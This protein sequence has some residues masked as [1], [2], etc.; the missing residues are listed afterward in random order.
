[1][2]RLETESSF[3][4]LISEAKQF[5]NKGNSNKE[6][7]FVKTQIKENNIVKMGKLPDL[8]LP[9]FLGSYEKWFSFKYMFD[10]LVDSRT[11]LSDTDK[12]LYLKLCCKNDALKLIESL[13]VTSD[14]YTIALDL[15]TK[16]YENKKT[17]MNFHVK[18]IL[19]NLPSVQKESATHIRS[20]IDTVHQHKSASKLYEL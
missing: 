18:N 5:I 3:Y 6:N 13:N 11:D 19:F 15:L 10:S 4:D 1:M 14:N 2:H 12:S 20:L 7:G 9:T 8:G 17:V 16:R